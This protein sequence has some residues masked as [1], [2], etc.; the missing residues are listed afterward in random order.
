MLSNKRNWLDKLKKKNEIILG[1]IKS[2]KITFEGS[3]NDHFDGKPP[4]KGKKVKDPC[5][6]C[7]EDLYY[8]EKYSRRIALTEKEEVVGWVCPYCFSEFTQ[9][10][11]IVKIMTTA[12]QGEA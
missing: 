4:K 1:K 6:V 11:D 8:S 10:D 2:V 12:P 5:M 3:I 9:N 7:E